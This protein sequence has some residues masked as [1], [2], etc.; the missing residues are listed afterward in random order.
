MKRDIA[1]RETIFK[2]RLVGKGYDQEENVNYDETY[3]PV[4]NASTMKVLLFMTASKN[5]E[6]FYIVLL[7]V[8]FSL[9]SQKILKYLVKF[10]G[11]RNHCMALSKLVGTGTII[12]R[13]YLNLMIFI[14]QSL[15]LDCF[16][17]WI[18]NLF[19]YVDDLLVIAQDKKT[20][21]ELFV[22]LRLKLQMKNLGKV[23]CFLGIHIERKQNCFELSQSRYIEKIIDSNGMND[24]RPIKYPMESFVLNDENQ[25]IDQTLPV[26]NTIGSLQYLAYHTRP[27]IAATIQF[28]SR[29]QSKPTQTLL[30][31]CKNILRYLNASKNYKIK[32]GNDQ[33]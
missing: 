24:C 20:I 13:C 12:C 19:V 14:N 17:I 31:A 16:S 18:S 25:S 28:L 30:H 5:Y 3:S 23:T 10:G 27:D 11:L 8:K 29:Y 32:L 21:D 22:S 26:R 2:T 33:Q 9:N 7:I 1:N 4:G 15:I 6:A